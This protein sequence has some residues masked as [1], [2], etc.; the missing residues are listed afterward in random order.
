[1]IGRSACWVDAPTPTAPHVA[2]RTTVRRRTR[3]SVSMIAEPTHVRQGERKEM[4]AALKAER[5][6]QQ[7]GLSDLLGQLLTIGLEF[8]PQIGPRDRQNR[9]GE[10][11]GIRRP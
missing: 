8:R 9:Q 2:R 5:S 1:M 4:S 10:Q 11:A 7:R 3:M 6:L